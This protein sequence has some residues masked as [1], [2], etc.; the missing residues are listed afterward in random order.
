[1]ARCACNGGPTRW[2]RRI[3][4]KSAIG[5]RAHPVADALFDA[6]ERH[7]LPREELL[8]LLDAHIF[9]L[10]DDAME[11][12]DE[13]ETYCDRTTSRLMRLSAQIMA[14]AAIAPEPFDQA[15][16][17][18]GLTKILRDLPKQTAAGQLFAPKAILAQCGAAESDM[19]SG[20]ATPP[21]RVALKELRGCARAHYKAARALA[22]GAGA[23]QAALLP[24]A[25]VPIYLDAM[26]GQN[27]NPFGPVVAPP[28]WRKQ[29]RLWRASRREG[30]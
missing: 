23:A 7:A 21:V 6:I 2:K 16:A 27:Y 19:R 13:L 25:L 8:D 22:K 18:L 12:L 3:W 29:W 10:Y 24:A 30:L 15:G 5:A 1:M 4:T 9:D 14:G 20:V 17:A 28:Q 26:E 11:T